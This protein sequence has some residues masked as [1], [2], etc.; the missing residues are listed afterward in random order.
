MTAT[1][2][3][4]PA[5]RTNLGVISQRS[6]FG[7]DLWN[8]TLRRR[9]QDKRARSLNKVFR[10]TTIN[11]FHCWRCGNAMTVMGT[12]SGVVQKTNECGVLVQGG[13]ERNEQLFVMCGGWLEKG[14]HKKV[15]L[16]N[17]RFLL[18]ELGP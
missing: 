3:L 13:E 2:I 8:N 9:R 10:N 11:V 1:R 15:Q 14:L 17:W 7:N 18:H 5:L 12:T 6:S 4:P 16:K